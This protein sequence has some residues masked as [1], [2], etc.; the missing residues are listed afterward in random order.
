MAEPK[1]DA[2]PLDKLLE[3]NPA[4]IKIH[5]NVFDS[6]I[7]KHG[8]LMRFFEKHP[9]KY[10]KLETP[11][12]FLVNPY[13]FE[14]EIKMYSFSSSVNQQILCNEW[15]A[16]IENNSSHEEKYKVSEEM[17]DIFENDDDIIGF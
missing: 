12:F 4:A 16:I 8:E 9:K 7:N 10:R 11:N 14:Y 1:K 17:L 3:N 15:R 6:P 5:K 2:K 13:Y